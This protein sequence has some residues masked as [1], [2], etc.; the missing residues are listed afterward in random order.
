MG[1]T[2]SCITCQLRQEAEYTKSVLY[3]TYT[4]CRF[5]G[6]ALGEIL[7]L[8]PKRTVIFYCLFLVTPLRFLRLYPSDSMSDRKVAAIPVE[9]CVRMT[10]SDM[11]YCNGPCTLVQLVYYLAICLVSAL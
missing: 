11:A 9:V 10:M 1:L 7:W 2:E 6:L 4:R 3:G 5:C 8:R